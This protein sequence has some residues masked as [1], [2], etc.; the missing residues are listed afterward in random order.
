MGAWDGRKV[1][2]PTFTVELKNPW[3]S[4][5]LVSKEAVSLDAVATEY[6]VVVTSVK[7]T[8]QTYMEDRGSLKVVGAPPVLAQVAEGSVCSSV[9]CPLRV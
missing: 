2:F 9:R 3:A 7:M 1:E 6:L 4:V 8:G 5:Y